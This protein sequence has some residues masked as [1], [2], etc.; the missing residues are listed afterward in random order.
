MDSTSSLGASQGPVLGSSEKG[1]SRVLTWG[2]N[3]S[4]LLAL[5]VSWVWEVR[6]VYCVLQAW[7]LVLNPGSP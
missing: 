2:V 5:G 6:V 1:N 4:F 7:Y 3:L